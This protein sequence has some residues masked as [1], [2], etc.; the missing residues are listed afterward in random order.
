[1]YIHTGLAP[2][3]LFFMAIKYQ[4]AQKSYAY[5]GGGY[6]AQ[7]QSTGGSFFCEEVAKPAPTVSSR[8]DATI[9]LNLNA[10]S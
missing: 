1:M 10:K 4:K 7:V 5:Q 6:G 9:V 3:Q 2:N 8:A